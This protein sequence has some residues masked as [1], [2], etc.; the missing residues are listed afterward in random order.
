[1]AHALLP[2]KPKRY[3]EEMAAAKRRAEKAKG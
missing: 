1:L 3:Q 2:E